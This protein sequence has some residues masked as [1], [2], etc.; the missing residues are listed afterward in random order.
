MITTWEIYWITRLDIINVISGILFIIP[1]GIF[2]FSPLLCEA[3]FDGDWGEFWKFVRKIIAIPIIALILFIFLPNTKDAVAIYIIPKIA[4]NE[5]IQKLP[6]NA[7]TFL[8]KKFEEWIDGM[9]K[10]KE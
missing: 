1:A 9:I 7:A 10:K 4:N 2:L 5:Q 3:I 6:G 8:N